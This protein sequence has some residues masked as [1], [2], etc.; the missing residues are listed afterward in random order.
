[1]FL[2]KTFLYLNLENRNKRTIV[3]KYKHKWD[4]R[5]EGEKTNGMSVIVHRQENRR[6]SKEGSVTE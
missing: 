5:I 6:V 4:W 3:R 2:L 1:M